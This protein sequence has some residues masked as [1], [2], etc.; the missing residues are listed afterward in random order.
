MAGFFEKM[1]EKIDSLL[2]AT[3]EGM[4]G[5]YSDSISLIAASA[6]VLYGVIL[7]FYIMGGK[8]KIEDVGSTFFHAMI[9]Y[10][11]VTNAGGY[12]NILSDG[13]KGLNDGLA[14][15]G[16]AGSSA[17]S[18]L[19]KQ[20]EVTQRLAETVKALDTD[21]FSITGAIASLMIWIGTGVVLV[22]SSLVLLIAKIALT[23]LLTTA[24]VFIY[25]LTFP[26]LRQTFNNW[27]QN[28]LSSILTVMFA[29]LVINFGLEFYN[30]ILNQL[31]TNVD[32]ASL[33]TTGAIAVVCGIV[34]GA[35]VLVSAKLAQSI[36]GAGIDAAI[37]GAAA[38]GIGGSILA[39]SKT[40]GTAK[41]IGTGAY[42][43]ASGK[44]WK[45]R[46]SKGV[47]PAIA[48]GSGRIGRAAIQKVIASNSRSKQS[49]P[50]ARN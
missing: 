32:N 43:G 33:M 36:S 9:I 6:L 5:K 12:L 22:I 42:E 28:V 26:F 48:Y 7:A 4:S 1:N 37:Q 41:D 38:M 35:I 45:E 20:W 47:T 3:S 16:G 44:N 49:I 10:V 18:L 40:A 31:T 15:V 19:D 13:I 23:L 30:D 50:T 46:E 14:T 34:A 2:T 11:F 17:W 29:S 39:A 25:C 21:Y 8:K 27:V 24:P